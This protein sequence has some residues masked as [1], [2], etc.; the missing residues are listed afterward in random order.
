MSTTPR[1]RFCGRERP[2]RCDGDVF[3]V[4]GDVPVSHHDLAQLLV[5]LAGRGSVRFVEW[6]A[7]KKRIDIGSF[8]SDSKKFRAATGWT[9]TVPLEEGL[10]RTLAFY[11]EHLHAYVESSVE[12]ETTPVIPFLT[13]TPGPRSRGD[14]RGHRPGH[15]PRLVH[16]R[17][18][19]RAIRERVRWQRPGPVMRSASA[20]AP[21]RWRLPCARLG[22]GRGDEVITSPLSA[23]Y[24]ALAI[25]MVGARPVF[26]DID[27]VRLTID[28]GAV[29]AAVT[30]RTAAILP[31]HIY[32][33]AADMEAIAAVAARHGLA[34]VEDCCQAHLAT[35][36]GRP[37]GSFGVAG[38][39]QLLSDQESRRAR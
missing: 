37:V 18:R 10:R 32:G 9:P 4:G 24:T 6:P 2:T 17:P 1:M 30:S 28:P 34:I 33:Q 21:M 5:G 26:A 20:M 31:V 23:A 14:R 38:G 22:I 15:R 13:L 3:N 7:D 16:P 19:A 25:M 39:I 11:R 12:A 8:Y 36:G 29:A 27:P 35:C